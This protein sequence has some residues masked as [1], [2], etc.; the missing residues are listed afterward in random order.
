[1]PEHENNPMQEGMGM[2]D[3]EMMQH[4]PHMHHKEMQN[5]LQNCEETCEHLVTHLLR[6]TDLQDR[7]KQVELLRDCAD[8]CALTRRYIARDSMFSKYAANLCAYVCSI[9]GNECLRFR[10]E[11]SQRCGMICH[12]CARDCNEFANM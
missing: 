11:E 12:H 2:E 5:T 3:P 6:H 9:C 8:F 10:D 4:M 1:M 7:S